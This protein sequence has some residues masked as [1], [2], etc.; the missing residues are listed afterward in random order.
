M[1]QLK[2][3]VPYV[4]KIWPRN[5]IPYIGKDIGE[6]CTLHLRSNQLGSDVPYVGEHSKGLVYPILV[7]R[8]GIGVP[9]AGKEIQSGDWCT[10]YY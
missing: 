10:L 4:G 3:G 6:W 7:R 9:Y 5:G 2:I 1:S 8:S